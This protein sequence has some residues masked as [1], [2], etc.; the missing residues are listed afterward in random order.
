MNQSHT[1]T[2]FERDVRITIA[3]LVACR[4]VSAGAGV[5]SGVCHATVPTTVLGRGAADEYE[6]TVTL[7]VDGAH[8]EAVVAHSFANPHC[9][10]IQVQSP[11]LAQRTAEE[12]RAPQPDDQASRR[13]RLQERARS[14][15]QA[16]RL[17]PASL[18]NDWDEA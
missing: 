4:L 14:E 2:R 15:A 17:A 13:A 12:E 6:I 11:T 18:S 9:V 8:I 3:H 10:D 1:L 7:R 5:E 16:D